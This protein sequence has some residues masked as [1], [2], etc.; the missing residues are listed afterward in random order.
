MKA[1]VAVVVAALAFGCQ[2]PVTAKQAAN[3]DGRST[4]TDPP[5]IPSPP[6]DP[7]GGDPTTQPPPPPAG[8]VPAPPLP[9]HVDQP[10]LGA[11]SDV[12]PW[13]VV[14]IHTHLLPDGRVMTW[15][16][17]GDPSLWNPQTGEFASAPQTVDIFCGGHSLLPDGRLLVTGGNISTDHGLP[18]A[19]VFDYRS[20]EWAQ[21]PL[22]ANGR[23]YPTNTALPNGEMLVTAG[24]NE[25]GLP[26]AIPEVWQLDGTWRQLSTASRKM[27]YY[28]WMFVAPTGRVFYAGWEPQSMWLDTAGT[29]KWT[30]GPVHVVPLKRVYGTAAMYAPG[31]I[32]VAGGADNPPIASAE[33][34]DLNQPTPAWRQIDP[35]SHARHHAVATVLPD[36]QVLITGG[37]SSAGK[38]DPVGAAM[39][40]ELWDPSTE[41]WT[42]MAPMAIKRLYHSSAILLPDARVLVGGGGQPA[43]VGEPNH[44]DVQFYAPPYLFTADGTSAVRPQISDA[45]DTIRYRESFKVATDSADSVAQVT[46]VKLGSMTHGFN[47][48]QMFVRL[49]FARA[50]GGLTVT[51]PANANLAPPGHYMLFLIGTKGTPSVA[52]FIHIG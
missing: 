33:V 45:P 39:E 12:L 31:K 38:N 13:H 21:G 42:Q 35:M 47:Q 52:R 17:S 43:A 7:E 36:G 51:A 50:S 6:P 14:S 30:T 48:S 40:P 4:P 46:L 8:V 15:G 10:A 25:D 49:S 28:P 20:G 11:W 22:M 29:G 32:L 23:W 5:A 1:L 19:N 41:T 2:R 26:N 27:A 34:I 16:H 9:S 37:S 44:F 24:E 3:D 18:N